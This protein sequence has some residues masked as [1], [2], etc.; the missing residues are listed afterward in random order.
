MS[1]ACWRSS[2]QGVDFPAFLTSDDADIVFSS[3]RTTSD[4]GSVLQNLGDINED[5]LNDIGVAEDR[6][7]NVLF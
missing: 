3:P 4:F 5:E 7:V 2:G 6:G 1:R